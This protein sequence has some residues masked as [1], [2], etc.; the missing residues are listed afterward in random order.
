MVQGQRALIALVPALGAVG[1]LLAGC[2]SPAPRP[3]PPE[4]SAPY[5][6]PPSETPVPTLPPQ[7]PPQ[8]PREHHLSPATRSL[9]TQAHSQLSRG[10]VDGASLTLD[11]ALR[12]E[13][14]NPLLWTE[15]ARVRLA[16]NDAHQAEEC[17]RKAWALAAGDLAAQTQAAHALVDALRMQG[18]NQDAQQIEKSMQ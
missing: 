4:S 18:R 8:P 16:E 13:P 10:D 14:S 1:L 11:R 12:I 9:V 6:T 17:A 5:V 7:R 2:P 3:T 15:L